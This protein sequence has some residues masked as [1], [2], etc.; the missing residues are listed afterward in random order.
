MKIRYFAAAAA[1][2]LLA[3]GAQAGAFSAGLGEFNG[4]GTNTT[5][6]W[7]TLV[8]AIT[9]GEIADSAALS[10]MFGNSLSSSTSVHAVYA[11]G[12]EV[13]RCASSTDFCWQSG[14]QAWSY[15]FTGAELAIFN[16]GMVNITTTQFDCCV[17]REGELSLRGT[18]V[19]VPE[20]GTYALMA[21]GLVG[22]G[23]VA[24]RRKA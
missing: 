10:G 2:V 24:R 14:P 18:T 6:A 16:D 17:V 22:I 8:F 3:S 20:P 21:L 1:A 11:D 19:P 13:A 7:G 4:N 23:V 12:I 9:P 5:E 15:T